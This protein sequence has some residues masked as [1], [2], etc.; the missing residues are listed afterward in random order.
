MTIK[1]SLIGASLTGTSDWQSIKW[2]PAENLVSRLQM[3]IAKATRE[4][5]YNK[6]KALQRLLTRSHSAK[7][8]SV[9]KVT[10]NKGAKTP[11][12]D[13]VIW[14]TDKQ[15]AEAVQSLQH[16]NYTPMPVRRIYI[17][18][19][20][21]RKRPLGIMTMKDRAMQA[22]SLHALEPVAET[23]A[24]KNSY[25]FRRY[26]STADAIAQVFATLACK[27]RAKWILECDIE[28]CFDRIDHTWLKNNILTEAKLL[29]KWLQAGYM[30]KTRIMQTNMG[31]PQGAIISPCWTL[32]TLSGLETAI[33]AGTKQQ[34]KVNVVA[35]ADDLVITGNSK[36]LLEKQI[37]PKVET[38]LRERGLNLSKEKTKVVHIEHGF[39]F[40][41]FNV[42]KYQEKLLIKP[43]KENI[44]D[45][46]AEIRATVKS[47]KSAKTENLINLL[48]PKIRGWANYYSKVVSKKVF[49]CVDEEIYKCL[50]TW[51]KRRHPNKGS[52]WVRKYFRS[53]D[54]QNWIFSAK[55]GNKY[56]NLFKASQVKIRRHIKIKKDAT[57]FDPK[58][59]GYFN[60]R[61]KGLNDVTA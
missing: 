41:G 28:S 51:A 47:N 48:N 15:K 7:L 45:F 23:Q 11:G 21:G 25:G 9:R 38:F 37:K 32:I 60:W 34:D 31:T 8:L 1:K 58:F 2:K 18:K 43:A 12:I 46:L 35:Y 40:L 14:R 61:K 50:V 19:S 24:D 53:Q 29:K 26:R 49:S 10:R 4:G 6:V 52:L 3:R 36:E 55:I 33:L 20:N 56:L 22:L 57:P 13:G 17:T 44:K 5:K 27:N 54:T 59:T 42:R 39:D 30:E 16:G